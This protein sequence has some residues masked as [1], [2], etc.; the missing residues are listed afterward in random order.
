MARRAIKSQMLYHLSYRAVFIKAKGGLVLHG[1][2][3]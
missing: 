2:T 3:M 1:D